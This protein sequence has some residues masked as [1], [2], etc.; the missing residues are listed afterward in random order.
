MFILNPHVMLQS[1]ATIR[2][3]SISSSRSSSNSHDSFTTLQ[4]L[5][6]EKGYAIS[7]LQISFIHQPQ[8]WNTLEASLDSKSLAVSWLPVKI[9]AR[10]SMQRNRPWNCAF[11]APA[12]HPLTG[13][14]FIIKNNPPDRLCCD[15]KSPP[16]TRR[17]Q[18]LLCESSTPRPIV[19]FIGEITLIAI[20]GL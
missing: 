6:D 20:N 9:N 5:S 3:T 12:R 14:T 1:I 16:T 4:L 10:L 2:T 18:R 15:S 13:F 11:M 17:I 19:S 8:Y 7:K